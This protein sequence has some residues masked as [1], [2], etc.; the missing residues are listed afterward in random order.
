MM[1]WDEKHECYSSLNSGNSMFFGE[2]YKKTKTWVS[3]S[4]I[5]LN[6]VHP[7]KP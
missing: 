6:G 7:T 1:H 2:C 5:A 4:D 3:A